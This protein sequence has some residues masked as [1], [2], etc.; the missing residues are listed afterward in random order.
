MSEE[1]PRCRRNREHDM[2]GSPYKKMCVDCAVKN[3]LYL[4]KR[5]GARS[6]AETGLGRPVLAKGNI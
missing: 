1:E 2:D 6:Q 4:R 3:R 5:T